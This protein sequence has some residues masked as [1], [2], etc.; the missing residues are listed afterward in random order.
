MSESVADA[1]SAVSR[2]EVEKLFIDIWQNILDVEVGPDDDVFDLGG[3]SLL[4]VEAVAQ[5]RKA[6]VRV[7]VLDVFEHP[8]PAKLAGFLAP[9][10]EAPARDPAPLG[11]LVARTWR[12]SAAPWDAGAPPALVPLVPDGQGEPLFCVHVG[13]GHVRFFTPIA[14]TLRAGRPVYGFE[15][16]GIKAAVRP[17]LTIAEIAE[18]YLREL[19]T[20]QPQGPYHLTGFCS[21]ALIAF[22]MAQ[23]LRAAGQDVH[24][25]VLAGPPVPELD[26]GLGLNDLFQYLLGTLRSRFGLGGPADVPEVV[27]KLTDLTWFEEELR[28]E[29]LY[30]RTVLWAAILFAQEHYDPRPYDGPVTVCMYGNQDVTAYWR[31]RVPQADVIRL[32]AVTTLGLLQEQRFGEVLRLLLA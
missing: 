23:R 9:A 18:Q 1:S 28:P 2:D 12:T 30:R 11:D 10:D 7:K 8:T 15:M 25:L 6:G 20:V 27:R 13:T 29:E 26:P 31:D 22:E 5:A 24:T 21:G 16:P 17:F 19:R 14:E 3:Y 4:V 32:E